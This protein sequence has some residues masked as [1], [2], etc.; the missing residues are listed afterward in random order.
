MTEKKAIP[1]KLDQFKPTFYDIVRTFPDIK[2]MSDNGKTVKYDGFIGD[3]RTALALFLQWV[4]GRKCVLLG[5]PAS[6]GKTNLLEICATYC[7]KPYEFRSGSEK[8]ELYKQDG[9]DPSDDAEDPSKATHFKIS[10]INRVTETVRE[11]L[12]YFGEGDDFVYNRTNKEPVKIKATGF[13]TCLADENAVSVRAL[14]TELMSR[15]LTLTLDGTTEQTRKVINAMFNR[16]KDPFAQRKVDENF[17]KDCQ[18]YIKR[19]PNINNFHVI[20]P[21]GAHIADAV[22]YFFTSNRR[23]AQ[24][25][26]TNVDA[27]TM[28][29]YPDRLKFN[30]RGKNIMPA[31]PADIWYNVVVFGEMLRDSA[32]KCDKLQK[33]MMDIL[34]AHEDQSPGEYL[35]VEQMHKALKKLGYWPSLNVI[36]KKLD[37]MYDNGYVYKNEYSKNKTT[38]KISQALK[39]FSKGFDWQFIADKCYQNFKSDWEKRLEDQPHIIDE[40]KKLCEGESLLVKHPFTGDVIDITKYKVDDKKKINLQKEKSIMDFGNTKDG[41]ATLNTEDVD[42][43]KEMEAIT[44]EIN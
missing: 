12:K 20:M 33:M 18:Q 8:A 44:E 9:K 34:E 36:G 13:C 39:S 27:I 29:N 23:D 37:D 31:T 26:L 42:H 24:K 35:S 11:M 21:I 4:V 10:E 15:M 14:G 40:Y 41:N 43:R 32:L 3:E 25:W 7:R 19:L 16:K 22:P 1:K 38:Y 2:V 17:I 5:G 28:F 30:Y 6:A